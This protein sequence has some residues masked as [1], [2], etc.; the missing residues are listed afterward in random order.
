[1]LMLVAE[2]TPLRWHMGWC[3]LECRI[4]QCNNY[5]AH[6]SHIELCLVRGGLLSV[7]SS[8]LVFLNGSVL[9]V[10]SEVSL[11]NL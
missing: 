3:E 6:S 9:G 2:D 5:P 1:V 7:L 4:H 8:A 11:G 10:A